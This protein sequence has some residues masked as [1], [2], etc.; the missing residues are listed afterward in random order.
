MIILGINIS[1]DASSCL[2]EDG[3]IIYYCEEERLS[4][5]KHH[6]P[7]MHDSKF[8]GIEKLK[9]YNIKEIDKLI[10]VTYGRDNKNEDLIISKAIMDKIKK[11][12]ISINNYYFN[13]QEH[14]LYHAYVGHYLSGF[15]YSTTIVMDGA[16]AYLNSSPR[17]REVE[18]IYY[19]DSNI[20]TIYKHYS[21]FN[22]GLDKQ[23]KVNESDDLPKT[24][25]SNSY[26]PGSIFGN[27]TKA[28]GFKNIGAD[29]GKTMG[30]SSYGK[31]KS[32]TIEWFDLHKDN[33][34]FN[35][36]TFNELNKTVTAQEFNEKANIA[37]KV[38]FETKEYTLKI[39]EKAIKVTQ[40]KNIVLSGGY[41]LNCVNN[42]EYIKEFPDI[43][44]YVDPIA[45]D[46]GT[47]IGACLYI[48]H[49]ILGNKNKLQKLSNLYLG[50]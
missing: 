18:S 27:F 30:M 26:S 36:N 33:Y 47:A 3:N 34:F 29:A 39:I 46:G 42:Y 21:N 7:S 6:I 23:L 25:F 4:K 31:L 32:N 28:L 35:I 20:K 24:I 11:E 41:F 5:K 37:K 50:G 8:Y 44:F 14:H 45:Y 13:T 1:H 12:N 49:N 2:M 48:W 43:N 16:G 38:Q 15:D 40:T 17:Y 10:F 22:I 19:F 9:K